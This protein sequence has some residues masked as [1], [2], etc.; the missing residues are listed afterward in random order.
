MIYSN[1]NKGVFPTGVYYPETPNTNYYDAAT[2]W[3]LLVQATLTGNSAISC[4]TGYL[5]NTVYGGVQARRVFMCPEA[6][7]VSFGTATVTAGTIISNC[8]CYSCNPRVLGGQIGGNGPE[9][10]GTVPPIPPYKVGTSRHPSETA[11]L[12]DASV[13]LDM[14]G[15]I[16]QEYDNTDAIFIDNNGLNSWN[17]IAANATKLYGGPYMGYSVD[18]TPGISASAS[19]CNK[20]TGNNYGNIRF[21]H[22]KN[23][24]ANVLFV[25]GHVQ[26][27]TLNPKLPMNSPQKTDFLRKYI[28]QY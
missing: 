26:S 7:P 11:V 24:V 8:V 13:S 17:L 19:D 5:A 4:Y 18:M 21:R 3:V 10:I 25:D 23:T 1:S 12:F 6:P 9:N 22:Y 2:D 28:Y 16:Y 27:F 20:D 14:P 15:T